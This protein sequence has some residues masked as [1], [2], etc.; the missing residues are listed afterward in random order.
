VSNKLTHKIHGDSQRLLA[1]SAGKS[2]DT[3]KGRKLHSRFIPT[4][5]STS[6]TN[7]TPTPAATPILILRIT[8]TMDIVKRYLIEL[9]PMGATIEH[10]ARQRLNDTVGTSKI[11]LYAY[12]WL[13][14]NVRLVE[15]EPE[16]HL[17]QKESAMAYVPEQ[18]PAGRRNGSRD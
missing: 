4:P 11:F 10:L 14:R 17:G 7:E 3:R 16:S 6:E 18:A 5:S 13:D 9:D 12:P 8:Y 2:V 15:L 1:I